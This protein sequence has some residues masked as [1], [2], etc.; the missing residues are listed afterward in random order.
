MAVYLAGQVHIRNCIREYIL[1]QIHIR[2]FFVRIDADRCQELIV[3][4]LQEV[5]DGHVR[6][7]IRVVYLPCADGIRYVMKDDYLFQGGVGPEGIEAHR[8]ATEAE[9]HVYQPV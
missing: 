2:L 9:K 1:E 3:Q 4:P 8:V 6:N 7:Q 5:R